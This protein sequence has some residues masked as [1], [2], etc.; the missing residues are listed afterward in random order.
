VCK[1]VSCP[2]TKSINKIGG[3]MRI[4]NNETNNKKCTINYDFN[5]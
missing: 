4:I 2:V 5:F 3:H 1:V